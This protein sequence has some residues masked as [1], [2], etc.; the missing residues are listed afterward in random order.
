[1]AAATSN[2][3]PLATETYFPNSGGD[4]SSSSG[5]DNEAGASGDSPGAVGL[6]S[7]AMIAII[8]VVSVVGA[9]GIGMAVLFYVAKKREWKIRETM[10]K[11]A[12]K[13][14]TALTPRRTEFPRSVK[15]SSPPRSH[16]GR[17]RLN[18]VPPTPR[19]RPEDLEKGLAQ[20][21]SKRKLMRWGR[22]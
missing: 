21:E 22:K 19:L 4:A 2:Y 17:T 6:S 12:R 14:V 15:E 7:D 11:S 9:L 3:F 16:R 1:M 10:R 18:D 20:A 13:V 8:V 5:V